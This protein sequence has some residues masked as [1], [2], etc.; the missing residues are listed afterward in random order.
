V[1]GSGRAAGTH[2]RPA[3]LPHLLCMSGWPSHT[4]HPSAQPGR[5]K[6]E[7]ACAFT[8][9]FHRRPAGAVQTQAWQSS[10]A[11][12]LLSPR[13]LP[14]RHGCQEPMHW[15]SFERR[16]SCPLRAGQHRL[17]AAAGTRRVREQGRWLCQPPALPPAEPRRCAAPAQPARPP[18]AGKRALWVG[19]ACKG[20]G[21]MSGQQ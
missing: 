21:G 10:A 1:E 6:I 8:S 19:S 17:S 13:S 16:E 11:L 7:Q 20:A 2:S 15:S 18:A 5:Q 4:A 14:G 9:A 12:L 3:A